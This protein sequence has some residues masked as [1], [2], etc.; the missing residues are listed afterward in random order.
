MTSLSYQQK[1]KFVVSY[2]K[3]KISYI[4]SSLIHFWMASIRIIYVFWGGKHDSEVHFAIFQ[5]FSNIFT[6]FVIFL[7]YF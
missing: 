1:C 3:N 2:K 6:N 4:F 5:T 7:A